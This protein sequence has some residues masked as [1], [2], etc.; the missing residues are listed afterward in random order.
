MMG[1]EYNPYTLPLFA[2][3]LVSA[4]LARLAW[5]RRSARGA[6]WLF[7]LMVAAAWWSF[8]YGTEIGTLSLNWQMFWSRVQYLGI[9]LIPVAWLGMSLEYAGYSQYVTR[10]NIML[11]LIIPALVVLAMWTNDYHH[12]MRTDIELD[13]SG[14]FPLTRFTQGPLY[15][16]NVVYSYALFVAATFL[17]LRV[18]VRT[19][20]TFRWQAGSLMVAAL[21][22]WG[23]NVLY[24]VY[25]KPEIGFDPTPI[26]FALTGGLMTWDLMSHQFLDIAPVAR[27]T[28]LESMADLVLVLDTR[29]RIVDANRAMLN[30]IGQS[31]DAVMGKPV[32]EVFPNQLDLVEQYR[33]VSDVR[34]EVK[35]GAQERYFDLQL[36][37]VRDWQD[38]LLGTL[39]VLR[40]ITERRRTETTLEES[41]QRLSIL[42]RIDAEL[43]RQ[44]DVDYVLFSAM[45]AAIRM[46]YADAGYIA[47][48]DG[49]RLQLV[50]AIGAY[51]LQK[52]AVFSTDQGIIGRVIREQEGV[53]IPDVSVEADFAGLPTTQAQMVLP[54]ASRRRFLGVLNLETSHADF[55]N[56]ETF[57]FI[58]LLSTRIAT[59]LDNARAY[60]ELERLVGELDAFAHTVAHDLKNPLSVT[61][62]YAEILIKHRDELNVEMQMHWLRSIVRSTGKMF[63]IIDALLMLAGVRKMTVVPSETLDMNAIVAEV[64]ERLD[65]LITQ[66]EAQVTVPEQWPP[67]R[68]YTPWVEEVLSNYFS[69][70][71]KYGGK[72]PAVELGATTEDGVVRIWVKDNGYGLTPEQQAQLFRPFTRLAEGDD[73]EGHGLGLSIVH[74]IVEKMG[75]QVGVKSEPGQGSVFS[76]TLPLATEADQTGAE[77]TA[78]TPGSD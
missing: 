38:R 43:T 65:L 11:A 5:S 28:I 25:L 7:V 70:A 41:N 32:E 27:G 22:P 3:A 23:A 1:W 19:P 78:K 63:D 60:Q 67:V 13:T 57:E 29:W 33:G 36:S 58:K 42:R 74:R 26:A 17:A 73:I 71:L 8:W 40:D 14:P 53:L 15:W 51:S 6:R 69:N 72:P 68:G 52:G 44:L 39:V 9:V 31:A 24:M 34:T 76:F 49:D 18:F 10:G 64:R 48:Q 54:L 62:G 4:G 59:A 35:L 55:F 45:D 16:T 56:G 21:I 2:T 20:G 50:N 46:S 61:Q 37:P 47:L 75:G 30:E 66:Y 77:L 12:L